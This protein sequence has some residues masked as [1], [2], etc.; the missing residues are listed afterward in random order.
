M[1][2]QPAALRDALLEAGASQ[3]SARKAAEQPAGY[4][5]RLAGSET[6]LS[7]LTW[8]SGTNVALTIGVL[9]KLFH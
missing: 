5:N 9:I 6:R 1:A 8:I 4:E 2:L 7:V 3:E